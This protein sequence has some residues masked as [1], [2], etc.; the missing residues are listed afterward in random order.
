MSFMLGEVAAA[1]QVAIAGGLVVVSGALVA[2]RYRLVVIG[3]RL[4]RVGE[5]VITIGEGL[6]A[7]E[8][9]TRA[10]TAVALL[11]FDPLVPELGAGDRLTVGRPQGPP[12]WLGGESQRAP[13]PSD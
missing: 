6:I 7:L 11:S 1:R 5:G 3:G 12:R 13:R 2:D 8:R 10:R 4:V 9:P